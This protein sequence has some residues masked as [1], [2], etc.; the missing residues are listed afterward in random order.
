MVGYLDMHYSALVIHAYNEVDWTNDYIFQ[1]NNARFDTPEN[2]EAART[3]QEWT[4]KYLPED[5]QGID[6]NTARSLFYNKEHP[7][8]IEGSWLSANIVEQGLGDEVGFFLMPHHTE[9]HL[10]LQWGGWGLAWGIRKTSDHPDLAAEYI[11]WHTSD[12]A[13]ELWITAGDIPAV[14][15]EDRSQVQYA[16]QND[17]LDA[18]EVANATNSIG[19]FLDWASPTMFTALNE[20]LDL[21]ETGQITPE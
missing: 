14:G 13:A 16:V 10:P 18:W 15:I 9:G 8:L 7:M 5:F 17:L 21:L 11:E 20:Q 2:I 12:R 4:A 6:R 19:H 3:I 1:R